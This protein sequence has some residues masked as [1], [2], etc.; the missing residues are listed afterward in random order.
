MMR[1]KQRAHRKAKK[2]G[3]SKEGER[4]KRLQSEVQRSTRNAHGRYMADVVSN[5]L[6]ENTKRFWS[7]IKSKRQESTGVAPLI[8]K[9]T[10]YVHA[11]LLS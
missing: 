9:R 11:G 6:K 3:H 8:N 10:T 4:F 2:S 1:R 5:D 7:F